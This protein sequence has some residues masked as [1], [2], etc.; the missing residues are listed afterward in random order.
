[1]NPA[2]GGGDMDLINII[3]QNKID[4]KELLKRSLR[5]SIKN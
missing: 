1:M 5:T 4:N 3:Q 2:S